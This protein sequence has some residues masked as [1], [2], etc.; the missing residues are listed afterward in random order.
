MTCA[1]S[2][3][4]NCCSKY[5]YWLR[6]LQACILVRLVRLVHACKGPNRTGERTTSCEHTRRLIISLAAKHRVV[7]HYLVPGHER[8]ARRP[9]SIFFIHDSVGRK[10]VP[11]ASVTAV[12]SLSPLEATP[13]STAASEVD[14]AAG[15]PPASLA[16]SGVTASTDAITSS[17]SVLNTLAESPATTTELLSTATSEVASSQVEIVSSV[18]STTA[19]VTSVEP[20]TT[21]TPVSTESQAVPMETETE[22]I[23]S[24]VAPVITASPSS[25]SI[26]SSETETISSTVAPVI[27]ASPSSEPVASSGTT[28][29]PVQETPSSSVVETPSPLPEIP[30]SSS[31][32]PSIVAT[33]TTSAPATCNTLAASYNPSF[34]SGAIAPWTNLYG[35]N[36]AFGK[37]EVLF[38]DMAPFAP[39][40]GSHALYTTLTNRYTGAQNWR[41]TLQ[42]VYIPAGSN[43][44]CTVGFKIV[45]TDNRARYPVQA[46]LAIDNQVVTYMENGVSKGR[47]VGVSTGPE[48]AVWKT[49]GGPGVANAQDQHTIIVVVYSGSGLNLAA[50]TTFAIDN[51]QCFPTGQCTA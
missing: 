11:N 20:S 27:S 30:A 12:E 38:A 51:L 6:Q 2:K 41:F 19:L 14:S 29:T 28:P 39:L 31:P 47:F 8:I 45:Q 37:T 3:W 43:Y 36:T 13:E 21:P 5:S 49:L 48:E 33:S 40:D 42:N 17:P 34:E 35:A 7:F 23:S 24:T 9:G 26:A 16:T 32:V 44:N 18:A 25:E 50:S 1:G 15:Q 4:G 10:P 22:T 46:V